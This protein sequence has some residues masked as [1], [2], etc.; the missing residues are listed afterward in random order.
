LTLKWSGV[1]SSSRRVGGRRLPQR[2]VRQRGGRGPINDTE[3]SRQV[4]GGRPQ[5]KSVKERG[6][7]DAWPEPERRAL[8]V[9][10]EVRD[11]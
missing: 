10:N 8:W 9:A 3:T 1:G 2:T 11:G 4:G 7:K 6:R 5:R